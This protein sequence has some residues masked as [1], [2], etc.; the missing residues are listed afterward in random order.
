MPHKQEK[1]SYENLQ[2]CLGRMLLDQFKQSGSGGIDNLLD[3]TLA[4]FPGYQ[5]NWHHELICRKLDAWER[6]DIKRLMLF[7]PPRHGKTQLASRQ[8]PAYIFGKNPDASIITASYSGDLSSQ[9]NRDV[10][11][12]IDSRAYQGL[13]PK[14]CLYGKNVRTEAYGTYLRNSDLFEIVGYKGIYQSAGIGGGITGR[15]FE[16]GII[17]DPIKNRAEAESESYREMIFSWY[18]ST[19]YTRQDSEDARILLIL[20]R[21]HEDDLAGRLLEHQLNGGD[22]ADQWE[23]VSLPAIAENDPTQN[24]PRQSGEA[25]WPGKFSLEA[26]QRIKE[27][28]GVYDWEALYQQRPQPPGGGKIKRDWFQVIDRAPEG[29]RW[30]RFWDLAVSTKTSAD[31]TASVA[32]ATDAKGNFYPGQPMQKGTSISGI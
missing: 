19:F 3:F 7:L 20:T 21:W 11:R 4:T 23:V 22:Y 9:N 16:Y 31:Y 1:L 6:G 5:V 28:I 32:G 8:L 10:Q 25:L 2:P 24:D 18:T 27:N 17:D 29:L 12:I 13:F 15:G 30:S 14:T 26:L